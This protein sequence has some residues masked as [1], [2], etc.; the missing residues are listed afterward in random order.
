MSEIKRIISELRKNSIFLP[1]ADYVEARENGSGPH[2]ALKFSGPWNNTPE[3]A[4]ACPVVTERDFARLG[5]FFL[6]L[7]KHNGVLGDIEIAVKELLLTDYAKVSDKRKITGEVLDG[8]NMALEP[9]PKT[10]S[11]DLS[12]PKDEVEL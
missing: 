8:M 11:S 10:P 7:A 1:I 12:D 3:K 4:E 9:T 5:L 6:A 2:V